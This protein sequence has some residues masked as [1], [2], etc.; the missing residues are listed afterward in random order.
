MER[1]ADKIE[2]LQRVKDSAKIEPE[3]LLLAEFGLYFGWEAVL[4]V[5]EDKIS[6]EEMNKLLKAARTMKAIDR[7][8][9]VMDIYA[10]TIAPNDK[11]K[12]LKETLKGLR[13][14]WHQ[15]Q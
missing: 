10:A 15:T 12:A 2:A 14:Q 11:A 4:S 1:D 3:W 5:R 8:N 6:Y 13:N 7:Y 9:N